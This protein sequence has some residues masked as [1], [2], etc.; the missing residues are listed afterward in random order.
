MCDDLLVDDLLVDDL[1]VDDLLD[2]T[3]NLL[4]SAFSYN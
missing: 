3:F 4:K 2:A 1:L